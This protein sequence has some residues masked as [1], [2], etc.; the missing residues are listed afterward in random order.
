MLNAK[1][2][3]LTGSTMRVMP[4]VSI[5][6]EPIGEGEMLRQLLSSQYYCF[7]ALAIRETCLQCVRAGSQLEIGN[8]AYHWSSVLYRSLLGVFGTESFVRRIW[9]LVAATD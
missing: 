1:E 6:G 3:F 2:A 4:I 5:N 7:D 9:N 8:C